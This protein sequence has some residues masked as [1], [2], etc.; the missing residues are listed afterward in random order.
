MKD[1][2]QV[3]RLTI[4][5]IT[6]LVFH[7]TR[8]T[9]PGKIDGLIASGGSSRRGED[10]GPQVAVAGRGRDSKGVGIVWGS[11]GAGGRRRRRGEGKERG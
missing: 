11:R 4:L 3:T 5:A 9:I 2:R 8:H 1:T 10:G 6:I 7:Y